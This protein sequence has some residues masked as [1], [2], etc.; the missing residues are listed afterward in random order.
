MSVYGHFTKQ[1]YGKQICFPEQS[2]LICGISFY[3]EN[4]ADISYNTVLT[5]ELEP[6]NNYDSS[7]IAIMNS[8]KKIGYIPNTNIKEICKNN[9]QEPLKIINIKQINGNYGI[10]VIPKKFYT[11]DPLLESKIFFSDD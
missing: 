3:K 7:A 1:Y 10:R 6:D 5:M 8:G 9:I 2:F 4:C 11:Y